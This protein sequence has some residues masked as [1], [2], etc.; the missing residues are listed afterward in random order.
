MAGRADEV[1]KVILATPAAG[2]RARDVP[3][4]FDRY[5]T[6]ADRG[7]HLIIGDSTT[8]TRK[9]KPASS[10]DDVYSA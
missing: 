1:L 4:R 9:H 8:D 7:R 2:A 5:R 10:L 6:H 3:H